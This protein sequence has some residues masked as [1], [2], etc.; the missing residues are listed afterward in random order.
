MS[1]SECCRQSHRLSPAL[2]SASSRNSG[3]RSTDPTSDRLRKVPK[4]YRLLLKVSFHRRTKAREDCGYA[5]D[6][7]IERARPFRNANKDAR[8]WILRKV[9]GAH[10]SYV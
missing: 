3:M 2:V 6:P 5:I 1:D 10:H 7:Y 8:G 9:A 4:T